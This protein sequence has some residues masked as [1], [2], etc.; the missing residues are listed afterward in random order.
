MLMLWL[1]ERKR[2]EI[3]GV[4]LHALRVLLP[5]SDRL[6]YT[7]CVFGVLTLHSSECH[8]EL[9]VLTCRVC[10]TQQLIEDGPSGIRSAFGRDLCG[11]YQFLSAG[12]A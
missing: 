10:H 1:I 9:Q 3:C 2:V 8:F 4:S 7:W 12:G 6:S 11:T 5:G